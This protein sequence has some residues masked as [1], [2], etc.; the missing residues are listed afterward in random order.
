MRLT[1]IAAPPYVVRIDLGAETLA[2]HDAAVADDGTRT[3]LALQPLEQIVV[4]R[5]QHVDR[6]RLYEFQALHTETTTT[7]CET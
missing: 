1:T 7:E 3:R 5:H 4:G 6:L 2:E